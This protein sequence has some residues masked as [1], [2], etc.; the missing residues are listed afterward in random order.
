MRVKTAEE[1][2]KMKKVKEEAKEAKAESVE[3]EIKKA[4]MESA[5]QLLREELDMEDE[6][7]ESPPSPARRSLLEE[8]DPY[9]LLAQRLANTPDR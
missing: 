3:D 6:M 8:E 9:F 4:K 5:I 1:L 7:D 2:L